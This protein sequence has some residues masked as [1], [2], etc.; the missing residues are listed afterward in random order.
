MPHAALTAS[1]AEIEFAI[2]AG[3]FRKRAK[4]NPVVTASSIMN[5]K[6]LK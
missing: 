5:L 2:R 3:G 6:L 4:I 1:L